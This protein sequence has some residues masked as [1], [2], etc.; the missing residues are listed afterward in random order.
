ME[1]HALA[2]HQ[3][4]RT[5]YLALA[6]ADPARWLVIDAAQPVAAIHAQILAR[7]AA[8]VEKQA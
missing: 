5:G 4:V 1:N 8:M 2:F 7:V 6:T 3:R